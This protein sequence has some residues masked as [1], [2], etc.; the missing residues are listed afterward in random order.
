MLLND[1]TGSSI[2]AKY[3]NL[4][5]NENED[6]MSRSIIDLEI[7]TQQ[8]WKDADIFKRTLDKTAAGKHY[9]FYDGPPF[10]TGLPHYGHMLAHTMKD[11]VTR[12]RTAQGYYVERR[13]GWD[14]HGLP[15]ENNIEKNAKEKG[16]VLDRRTAAGRADFNEQCRA[17]VLQYTKDWKI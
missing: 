15:I 13:F 17:T 4:D 1:I 7:S 16:I 10:A 3:C 14:T 2:R 9:T 8:F 6:Y 5:G 12:F 11:A